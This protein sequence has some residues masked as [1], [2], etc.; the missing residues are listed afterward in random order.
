MNVQ[1]SGHLILAT[2]PLIIPLETDLLKGAYG[3]SEFPMQ[4]VRNRWLFTQKHVPRVMPSFPK[5][6]ARQKAPM[7][8]SNWVSTWSVRTPMRFSYETSTACI[9]MIFQTLSFSGFIRI[10]DIHT[11]STVSS[12]SSTSTSNDSREAQTTPP[13][14]L[15]AIGA[16]WEKNMTSC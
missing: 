11:A 1:I 3:I 16:D 14:P 8:T 4:M 13:K 6:Q 10:L 12:N 15:A 9:S 5:A 7:A 2:V